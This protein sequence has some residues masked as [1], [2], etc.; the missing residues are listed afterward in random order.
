MNTSGTTFLIIWIPFVICV[1]TSMVLGY[2]LYKVLQN[3]YPKYYKQIGEPKIFLSYFPYAP[4]MRDQWAVYKGSFYFTKLILKGPP[5]NFPEDE[6][7][8]KLLK[9]LR[10]TELIGVILFIAFIAVSP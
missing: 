7:L 4:S 8:L 9:Y 1:I 3:K 5:E 10:F 2:K 6:K